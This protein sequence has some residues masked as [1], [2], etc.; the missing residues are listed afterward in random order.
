MYNYTVV[1][2]PGV[3]RRHRPPGS[4]RRPANANVARRPGRL[5]ARTNHPLEIILQL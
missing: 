5:E 3:E 2:W 4:R 1:P